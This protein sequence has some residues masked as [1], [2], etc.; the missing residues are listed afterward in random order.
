[1]KYIALLRGINVGGNNKVSMKD[2][3]V[4][5]ES[6]GF[7]NVQTYINSG[8]VIFNTSDTNKADLTNQCEAVI[9]DYFGFK[10]VCCV[11]SA[12]DLIDALDNT[13]NWWGADNLSVHNAIFVIPPKTAKDIANAVGDI[14]PEYENVKAVGNIIFWSAP[15]VTF[16]RTRY[17]KI[18]GTDFYKYI[19]IRSYNTTKKL[20]ALC[21]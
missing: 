13:P 7:E 19:T 2:L 9:K 18:V 4:C 8:N 11:I 5:F 14:K 21:A 3:K 10:V 20:A 15:R 6:I 16:S 12:N 17:S 1:M